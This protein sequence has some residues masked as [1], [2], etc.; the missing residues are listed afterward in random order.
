MT[1]A[2]SVQVDKKDK[3][4]ATLILQR[5]GVTMSALINM[6]L[7][8]VIIKR[9]IPFE[10]RESNISNDMIEALNELE[11]LEKHIDEY[12]KS[13]KWNDLREYLLN[14]K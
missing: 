4:E 13:N 3:E 7:K 10:V 12:K 2:I 11:Y 5:L 6:T 9:G 14:D 8:Q 1:T